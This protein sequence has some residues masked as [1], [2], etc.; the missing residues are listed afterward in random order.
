M[1]TGPLKV[2]RTWL[3]VCRLPN[4]SETERRKTS[5]GCDTVITDEPVTPSNEAKIDDSPAATA[6]TRPA[7]LAIATPV[8]D[9]SHDTWLVRSTVV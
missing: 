1:S 6:V 2:R 4:A 7:E 3:T 8:D 5:G 9:D